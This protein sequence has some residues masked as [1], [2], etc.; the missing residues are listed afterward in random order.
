MDILLIAQQSPVSYTQNQHEFEYWL[1]TK[2][3]PT[4]LE[5]ILLG[6]QSAIAFLLIHPSTILRNFKYDD[7][8]VSNSVFTGK[9]KNKLSK[10]YL[11]KM[12][13]RVCPCLKFS[14]KSKVTNN[15]HYL[16]EFE[17]QLGSTSKRTI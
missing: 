10:I 15:G 2:I 3:P 11:K 7:R 16:K 1:W 6:V 13:N 12:R 4:Q 5:R 14:Q 8:A 17:F 9:L